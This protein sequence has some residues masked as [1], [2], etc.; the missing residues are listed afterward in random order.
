MT[1]NINQIIAENLHRLLD[2]KASQPTS[3][4]VCW[5]TFSPTTY[6]N[7]AKRIC[8]SNSKYGCK[9]HNC[10][11]QLSLIS[12]HLISIKNENEFPQNIG[13]L[14]LDVNV[15]KSI[16]ILSLCL[17][18]ARKPFPALL[19]PPAGIRFDVI[20]SLSKPGWLWLVE[21][22]PLINVSH[23]WLEFVGLILYRN[24]IFPR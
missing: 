19:S 13:W 11:S 10:I 8:S 15:N 21:A 18:F 22:L 6:L 23:M 14:G 1:D 16:Q 20:S 9:Q 12:L 4:K 2:W 24:T 5:E 17:R 3:L 7:L